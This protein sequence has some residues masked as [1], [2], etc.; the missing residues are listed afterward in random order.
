M[1]L[2]AFRRARELGLT[3][4]QVEKALGQAKKKG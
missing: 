1:L 4:E 2:V 3:V